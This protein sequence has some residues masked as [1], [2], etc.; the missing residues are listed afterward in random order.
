[1]RLI[2]LD[3]SGS[4]G[5]NLDDK[6]QPLFVLGGV[7]IND[8]KWHNVNDKIEKI[9]NDYN[10]FGKELHI[11]DI[12]NCKGCFSSWNYERKKNLVL[13]CLKT[14][15][16][17]ELRVIYFKVLKQNYKVYFENKTSLAL[18]KMLKIPPYIIAY[19]YILQIAEQY[20]IQKDDYGILIADEQDTQQIAKDTLN[21]LRLI[22]EPNIKVSKILETSFFTKSNDSNFLQLADIVA[23]TIKRYLEINIKELKEKSVKERTDFYN[24]IK[25]CIYEPKFDYAKHPI[26]KYIDKKLGE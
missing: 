4:S 2:Y 13:E 6:E 17:F 10:I 26:L 9:K 5:T 21:A 16:D 14:I 7:I 12:M 3:D 23:Y 19:S 22:D 11:M 25:D 18:Q 15:K 8:K 1:M 20:L 24:V